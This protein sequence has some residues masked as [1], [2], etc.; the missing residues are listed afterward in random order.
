[1]M[2][3]AIIMTQGVLYSHTVHTSAK[4]VRLSVSIRLERYVHGMKVEII[5]H[6][7][8][9]PLS[10]AFC[11]RGNSARIGTILLTS[12]RNRLREVISSR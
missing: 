7:G 6:V 10:Y 5:H 9:V 2:T 4:R 1:M 12:V 11:V 3:R 8:F